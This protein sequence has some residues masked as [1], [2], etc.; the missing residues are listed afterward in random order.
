M[1]RDDFL[2]ANEAHRRLV[3][4]HLRLL[5]LCLRGRA[6]SH[7]VSKTFERECAL[8]MRSIPRLKTL[9]YGSPEY[10][11]AKAQLGPALA[12][13]YRVNRHH[14][15]HYVVHQAADESNPLKGMTLVD[16]AEMLADWLAAVERHADGD[17]QASLDHN[18]Q[19]FHIPETLM[20]ILRNTVA[21][22]ETYSGER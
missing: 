22:M 8:F 14:P 17:I 20:Q 7:D 5:R 2:A 9:T 4:K 16:L 18:E 13:H 11:E 15:E 3:A 6:E 1:T 21:V 10:N 12:E 19:R